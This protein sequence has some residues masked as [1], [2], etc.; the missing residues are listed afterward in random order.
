MKISRFQV[1]GALL[2]LTSAPTA[3]GYEQYVTDHFQVR[4]EGDRLSVSVQ[5]EAQN[6]EPVGLPLKVRTRVFG[7]RWRTVD[8]NL[9][10]HRLSLALPETCSESSRALA[11]SLFTSRQLAE[12]E[13]PKVSVWKKTALVGTNLRAH[14]K[15]H[16][17]SEFSNEAREI[18]PCFGISARSVAVWLNRANNFDSHSLI[19]VYEPTVH[20]WLLLDPTFGAYYTVNGVKA[21]AI[22][23]GRGVRAGQFSRIKVVQFPDSPMEFDPKNYYIWPPL[24]FREI[25]ISQGSLELH[26]RG[27]S[28]EAR[29]GGASEISVNAEQVSTRAPTNGNSKVAGATIT[30]FGDGPQLEFH[31]LGKHELK[32][33]AKTSN[34]TIRDLE[35]PDE[36]SLDGL[37]LSIKDRPVDGLSARGRSACRVVE[38]ETTGIEGPGFRNSTSLTASHH[39]SAVRPT[40]ARDVP[41][42]QCHFPVV[43]RK[44]Y[45]AAIFARASGGTLANIQLTKGYPA[46]LPN[47]FSVDPGNWR[48]ISTPFF[49]AQGPQVDLT[50]SCDSGCQLGIDQIEFLSVKDQP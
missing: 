17:C 34:A 4:A 12:L 31:V 9:F 50:F 16:I 5:L 29:E 47:N 11:N 43:D 32:I 8:D 36:Q 14:S 15:S 19:E 13:N 39:D 22:D 20:R 3:M 38:G 7:E 18:L 48:K 37:Q 26:P 33:L 41:F 46:H 6:G 30:F 24:L 49:F 45:S 28:T 2:L 23:V 10:E 40:V 35:G 44:L 1:F 21:G 27:F 42:V 25:R